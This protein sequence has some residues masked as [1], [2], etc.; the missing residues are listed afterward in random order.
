MKFVD[1]SMF[2][3]WSA[4]LTRAVCVLCG[5]F[6][7]CSLHA[8]MRLTEA[9]VK[10]MF[11]RAISTNRVKALNS[12]FEAHLGLDGVFAQVQ[13][14][15][16]SGK[17][18]KPIGFHAYE[19]HRFSKMLVATA[20]RPYE[21]AID[22]VVHE[23]W[24]DSDQ[25]VSLEPHAPIPSI[26]RKRGR[27]PTSRDKEWG[28]VSAEQ[29]REYKRQYL[30]LWSLFGTVMEQ[31]RSRDPDRTD[32]KDFG[33]NC[34]DL[35]ARWCMMMPKNRC[36]ALYL[37]T[38]TM[39]GGAFM[40]HL[41]PLKL[42]IGMLENSGAERRHQIGKVH[43]RKSLAGGGKQYAG[44]ASHE[45]RTAF[46]TLRGV[47]IW[48]FGRDLLAQAIAREKERSASAKVPESCRGRA[49]IGYH[50]TLAKIATPPGPC[51]CE[52]ENQS[53]EGLQNQD[54][55]LDSSEFLNR[56]DR[57]ERLEGGGQMDLEEELRI[58]H[59]ELMHAIDEHGGLQVQGGQYIPQIDFR[60]GN[61]SDDES[62]VNAGSE[63]QS[64]L[65]G[66]PESGSNSEPESERDDC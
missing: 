60:S 31:M 62:S 45:N 16:G 19:C 53:L 66:C 23:V 13:S 41:L 7:F 28:G 44:M 46:L 64:S 3:G 1:H 33:K 42:T 5:R 50:N 36:G 21:P 14:E 52:P 59:G 54:M 8:H 39:H 47:L 30:H 17:A 34:R 29:Q 4:W 24:P 48:Q 38:L 63:D 61:G 9:L 12:A 15:H 55:D 43:F 37:H 10:P 18:W 51:R 58:E 35:G 22:R 2:A 11:A 57:L 56:N 65:S 25:V 20:T 40:E 49:D 6:C 27:K 32:L 26:S